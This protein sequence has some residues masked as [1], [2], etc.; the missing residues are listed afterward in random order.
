MKFRKTNRP[1]PRLYTE[2]DFDMVK[3]LA[4][5]GHSSREIGETLNPPRGAGTVRYCCK[6]LG[7]KLRGKPGAPFGNCNAR[8]RAT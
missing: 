2:R 8:G 7:I 5:L 3:R 6:L 1:A 4:A